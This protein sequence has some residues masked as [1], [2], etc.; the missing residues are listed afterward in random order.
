M[1]S[2]V[3]AAVLA[4]HGLKTDIITLQEVWRPDGHPDSVTQVATEL[5]AKVRHRGL[6]LRT[7]RARPP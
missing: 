3:S 2:M 6:A 4:I 7:S 1:P 5:E